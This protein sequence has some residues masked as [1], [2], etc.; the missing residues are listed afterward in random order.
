MVLK[1]PN[2][3]LKEY[4]LYIRCTFIKG[5]NNIGS[6]SGT[7]YLGYHIPL[8]ENIKKIT[9]TTCKTLIALGVPAMEHTIA[10]QLRASIAEDEIELKR[11]RKLLPVDVCGA[12]GNA[13]CKGDCKSR[14]VCVQHV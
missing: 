2:P 4:N 14:F 8:D 3:D 6:L 9:A 12:C 11:M 10:E 1:N 5:D 7:V 13:S